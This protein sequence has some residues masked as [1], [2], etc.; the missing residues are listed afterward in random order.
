MTGKTMFAVRIY[1]LLYYH[2]FFV[3]GHALNTRIILSAPFRH[4][5]FVLPIVYLQCHTFF[6]FAIF[7]MTRPVFDMT[8]TTGSG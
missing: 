2:V 6:R 8:R 7:D 3:V 4:V 5:F 1:T